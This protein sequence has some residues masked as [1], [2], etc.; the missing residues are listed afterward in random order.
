MQVIQDDL[1]L[2]HDCLHGAVNGE[3]VHDDD[4]RDA[5]VT[6][7][8]EAL[9]PHLVPDFDSETDE[10]MHSFSWRTCDCCHSHLGGER[11]RFAVL[12]EP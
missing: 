8:L 3:P 4:A 2:C 1:W 7:G 6:A 9:G 5:A 12:G 11:W 10:G